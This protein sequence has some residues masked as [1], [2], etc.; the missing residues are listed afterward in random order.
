MTEPNTSKYR[1]IPTRHLRR[2]LRK[3]FRLYEHHQSNCHYALAE[4]AAT[5]MRALS[6]E[7]DRRVGVA[8]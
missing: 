8:E 5:D 2:S 7:L 1:H 4:H 6:D 3:A